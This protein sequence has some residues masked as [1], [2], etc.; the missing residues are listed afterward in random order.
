MIDSRAP[1]MFRKLPLG[2]VLT[3]GWKKVWLG[4]QFLAGDKRMAY[5]NN[6]LDFMLSTFP[7]IEEVETGA[8]S[9]NGFTRQD[10]ALT[11]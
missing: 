3:V 11:S 5:Q 8:R 10:R 7:T 6:D 2:S 4:S 1:R 9:P